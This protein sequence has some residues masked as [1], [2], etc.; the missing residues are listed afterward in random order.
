MDYWGIYNFVT[1][2]KISLKVL[3]VIKLKVNSHPLYK[4]DNFLLYN[5]LVTGRNIS[6]LLSMS[7]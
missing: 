5:F 4:P 1:R 3:K 2:N 7:P 6:I